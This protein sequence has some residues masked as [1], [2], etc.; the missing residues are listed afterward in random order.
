MYDFKK[1]HLIEWKLNKEINPM[2]HLKIKPNSK[3]YKFL[4]NLDFEENI[5]H[6]EIILHPNQK[7]INQKLLHY[8][9]EKNLFYIKDNVGSG[10]TNSFL[11]FISQKIK[12]SEKILIIANKTLQEQWKQDIDKFFP[13]DFFYYTLEQKNQNFN[14]QTIFKNFNLVFTT[15]E[16]LKNMLLY[17]LKIY[18]YVNYVCFDEIQNFEKSF[19]IPN[20]ESVKFFVLSAD[21]YKSFWIKCK[22][23]SF[24]D[25]MFHCHKS[26][27]INSDVNF[28]IETIIMTYECK[29]KL[30]NNVDSIKKFVSPEILKQLRENNIEDLIKDEENLISW[31][32]KLKEHEISQLKE[33]LDIGSLVDKARRQE[34]IQNLTREIKILQQKKEENEKICNICC[35]DFEE[36]KKQLFKCCQNFIC[37]ECLKSLQNKFCPFCR[38]KSLI[39]IGI[40]DIADFNKINSLEIN[41][42]EKVIF[43]ILNKLKYGKN[44]IIFSATELKKIFQEIEEDFKIIRLKGYQYKR[45]IL[46]EEFN[47][48][49]ETKQSKILVLFNTEDYY[50]LRLHGASDIL[51]VNCDDSIQRKQIIGRAVRL[52]RT[53]ETL[54]VY[55]IYE[56]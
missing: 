3:I 47:Q 54:N 29:Y 50:G 21:P 16:F 12:H 7:S 18:S 20:Y 2:T 4:E 45:S 30:G 34:K 52:G 37:E 28:R 31:V 56:A 39:S 33:K 51:I 15:R 40:K 13:N 53:L 10:K 55:N 25:Y 19:L 48:I 9:D 8:F 11:Y 23:K 35:N 44:I 46:I 38:N 24:E 14:F 1:S 17:N 26:I 32:M 36:N 43:N 42:L 6:E 22:I 41:S 27:E 49:Q 5:K